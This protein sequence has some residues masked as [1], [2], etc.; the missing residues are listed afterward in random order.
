M[1]MFS[2]RALSALLLLLFVVSLSFRFA[3]SQAST[4][5][6]SSTRREA[7]DTD[8]DT[9]YIG[10]TNRAKALE[11]VCEKALQAAADMYENNE[12]LWEDDNMEDI[13][14]FA[15][16]IGSVKKPIISKSLLLSIISTCS[17]SKL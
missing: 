11:L 10:H 13:D 5:R 8:D 16:G 17:L 7:S 2:M 4:S 9:T 12:R 14:N 15:F 6:S 1:A 3:R